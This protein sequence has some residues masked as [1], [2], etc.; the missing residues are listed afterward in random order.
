MEVNAGELNKRIKIIKV[1]K[2]KD[3]DGYETVTETVVRA[4]WA[5]FSQTSGTELV[6]ANADMSEVMVRFLIRWSSTPMSRKMVVRYAGDDYE[7]EY[8][9]GY[10][11]SREYVELWCRRLTLEG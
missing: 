3:K 9:N 5:K 1:T 4:P 11:D 8:I 7:I 10:G 2:S 6:K